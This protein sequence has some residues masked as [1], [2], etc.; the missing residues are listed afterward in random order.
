MARLDPP[1]RQDM[2]EEQGRAYDAV[3]NRGGR[4]GGPNGIYIRIPELFALN[5]GMGDYLRANHLDGR[6]RELAILVTVRHWNAVYPW[7]VH[8][9]AA[10]K[11]GVDRETIDAINAH[12]QPDFADSDDGADDRIVHDV[13]AELSRSGTLSD[14]TFQ[15]ARDQLGFNRLLDLVA[16][17]SFYFGVAMTVGIFGV[18]LPDEVPVP[19][20]P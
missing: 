19:L 7:A 10:T 20:A 14:A 1:K 3:A 16:T 5:Q 8:V 9:R 11:E 12:R 4:L 17:V 18:D 13:A 2:N 6:R 15:K